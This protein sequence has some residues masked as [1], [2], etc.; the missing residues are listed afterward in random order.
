[1]GE[2]GSIA[3]KQFVGFTLCTVLQLEKIFAFPEACST[4]RSQQSRRTD[5][6][7]TMRPTAYRERSGQRLFERTC[8]RMPELEA[9]TVLVHTRPGYRHRQFCNFPQFISYGEHHHRKISIHCVGF[10]CSHPSTVSAHR[11]ETETMLCKGK[12]K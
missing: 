6:P 9:K 1:M 8:E 2:H 4:R 12:R 11:E 10:I 7:H 5:L 3:H